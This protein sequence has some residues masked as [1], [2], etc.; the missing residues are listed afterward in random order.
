MGPA[1]SAA[2]GQRKDRF[3]LQRD[4][5]LIEPRHHLAN[6]VLAHRLELR[7]LGQQPGVLH[8]E[9]IAEYMDFVPVLLRRQFGA[10]DELDPSH[11]AGRRGGRAALDRVVIG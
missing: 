5:H 3:G 11:Q 10:G 4:A 8:V 1:G 6:P 9:T 7:R 2:V